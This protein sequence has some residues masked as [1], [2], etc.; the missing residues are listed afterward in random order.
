MNRGP[1]KSKNRV[2]TDSPDIS[3]NLARRLADLS[4][5]RDTP[6]LIAYLAGERARLLLCK[7]LVSPVS[8]SDRQLVERAH[9]ILRSQGMDPEA[10][11]NRLEP[12]ALALGLVSACDGQVDYYQ[13]L[14]VKPSATASELR[15][16]YRKKAFEAHPDTARQSTEDVADFLT[17]KNRI[18]YPRER[19]EKGR[20]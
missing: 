7:A 10:L 4:Q 11:K 14:G 9:R 2:N 12:A 8:A 3:Q 16:A 13:V 19:G 5:I 20:I 17:V 6:A 1:L 15:A 18:R